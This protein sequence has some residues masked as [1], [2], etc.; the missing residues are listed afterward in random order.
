MA[1]YTDPTT[2]IWLTAAVGAISWLACLGVLP[3]VDRV[4]RRVITLT[5][6]GGVAVALILLGGS[7]FYSLEVSPP[8]LATPSDSGVAAQCAA[9]SRC[10]DCVGDANCGFCQPPG[11]SSSRGG[12]CVPGNTT[13][14]LNYSIADGG[15][16]QQSNA[17]T[18]LG[19][20]EVE[21]QVGSW[22]T[23]GESEWVYD[24]CPI[25]PGKV[26]VGG[27]LSLVSL[28]L[29]V[30]F[31]QP[32]MG[33]M[34]WTI[35]AEIYPLHARSM[36]VSVIS[37]FACVRLQDGSQLPAT[38]S[39]VLPVSSPCCLQVHCCDGLCSLG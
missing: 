28:G 19:W 23:G 9:H 26:N 4:G 24:A 30:A 1:G 17:S 2:A 6:L 5:S 18:S 21:P 27:W 20:L 16:M 33:P 10:F 3:F 25:G 29:Y 32:G 31:F 38:C 37:I 15:C 8:C 39:H 13:G 35:N 34:P 12:Y 22:N 7:F 11:N 14:P 36:A